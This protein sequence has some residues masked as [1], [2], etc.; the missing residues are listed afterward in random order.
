MLFESNLPEASRQVGHHSSSP[1]AAREPVKAK[2]I[3]AL[4]QFLDEPS[5]VTIV[6]AKLWT[7]LAERNWYL[8]EAEKTL[9]RNHISFSPSS[10]LS[11]SA[12][13]IKGGIEELIF[14]ELGSFK[15]LYPLLQENRNLRMALTKHMSNG[16]S[17]EQFKHLPETKDANT[18]S[19]A[20][21][22]LQK[23]SSSANIFDSRS[24]QRHYDD[25]GEGLPSVIISSAITERDFRISEL[26]KKIRDANISFTTRPEVPYTVGAMGEGI[27]SIIRARLPQ[28]RLISAL[29]AENMS[30]KEHLD[31]NV[32][33]DDDV[34]AS[35]QASEISAPLAI[36]SEVVMPQR[37]QQMAAQSTIEEPELDTGDIVDNIQLPAINLVESEELK[38]QNLLE[39]ANARI[40]ELESDNRTLEDKI[41]NILDGNTESNQLNQT[42]NQLLESTEDE[43]GR[44]TQNDDLDLLKFVD[45]L[46]ARVIELESS[47]SYQTHQ[48]DQLQGEKDDL[49]KTIQSLEQELEV[50]REKNTLQTRQ[51]ELLEAQRSDLESAANTQAKLLLDLHSENAQLQRSN[52]ELRQ[53]LEKAV[54]TNEF[55]KL[56]ESYSILESSHKR[57]DAKVKRQGEALFDK[58]QHLIALRAAEVLLRASL[59]K[60]N[61]AKDEFYQKSIESLQRFEEL[62]A[63]IGNQRPAQPRNSKTVVLLQRA[64]EDL[65]AKYATLELSY[66]ASLAANSNLQDTLA[67][68]SDIIEVQRIKLKALEYFQYEILSIIQKAAASG[69]L[70][71]V[72]DPKQ[73]VAMLDK[74]EILKRDIEKAEIV[75][76]KLL[77]EVAELPLLQ[78]L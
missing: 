18:N 16:N 24:R 62:K 3:R 26:E 29:I 75:R 6:E 9:S 72:L 28:I 4:N 54:D 70:A 27:E 50:A 46:N 48:R 66:Q 74:M 37:N 38:S 56:S 20:Q 10:D 7:D 76:A 23:I 60:A 11:L 13:S 1:G 30:L 17:P 32:L 21:I 8:C 47:V 73:V 5:I 55:S 78:L 51:L 57:L 58:D 34:D 19:V 22:V 44:Q 2:E 14:S 15:Y 61:Q 31:G 41:A 71:E 49:Q 77:E 69:A 45:K 25:R 40:A 39:I 67:N 63:Q 68:R 64:F 53:G 65:T 12:S 43:V 36:V 59:E 52:Q 42:P 35:T 33:A